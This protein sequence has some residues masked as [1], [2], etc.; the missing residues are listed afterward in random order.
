MVLLKDKVWTLLILC[1]SSLK[2]GC[3]LNVK[4]DW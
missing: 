1:V 4:D 2:Y 3:T